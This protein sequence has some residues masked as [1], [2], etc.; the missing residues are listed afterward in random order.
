MNVLSDLLINPGYTQAYITLRNSGGSPVHRL[1]VFAL[2]GQSVG[3]DVLAA[4]RDG[5]NAATI[6][7]LGQNATVD[8]EDVSLTT[9]P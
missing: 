2:D 8:R 9:L 3:D 4:M 7:G 1:A 6:T 5:I